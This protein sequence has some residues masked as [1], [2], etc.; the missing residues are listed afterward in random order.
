M[1]YVFHVHAYLVRA[2]CFQLALYQRYI[3][4]A[5]YYLI[6]RYG[7]FAMVTIWVHLKLFTFAAVA[8][9][10]AHYG[11]FVLLYIAPYQCQVL[12]AACF[13]EELLGQMRQSKLGFGYYQ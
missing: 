13:I 8:A 12:A 10:V 2:A 11:A 1:A 9:Y 3:V 5:F 7:G 6:M 4:Q